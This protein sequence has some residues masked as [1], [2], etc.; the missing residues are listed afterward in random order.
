MNKYFSIGDKVYDLTE[1]YPIIIDFLVSKG[2]DNIKNEI[3]RKTIGK[4]ISLETAL[5]VKG[6]DVNEVERQIVSLIEDSSFDLSSGLAETFKKND[7]DLKISGILPCPIRVQLLESLDKWLNENDIKADY[8]LQAASMGL[9]WLREK[10]LG[11]SAKELSDI[12]LSAGFSL[13]FDNEVM[14]EHLKNN[15]FSNV[16]SVSRFNKCFDNKEID[17]KDPKN[18]YTIIGVVPAIFMVNTALLGDRQFPKS[19]ADLL[20]PEFENTIAL[21]MSDLDLF[22]AVLLG[23]YKEYGEEG[24]KKLGK[25]LLKSMHPA[26][27]IKEGGKRK[28]SQAPIITV[29]PYFF[30]WMAKEGSDLKPVW[31]DDGAIISPIFLITKAGAGEK[32]KALANYLF[33]KEMGNVMSANGKFPSTHPQVDNLLS[34]EQRFLWMGWDFIYNNDIGKLLKQTEQMFYSGIEER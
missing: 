18:Q 6:F 14:G 22:N 25:G 28:V 23:I 16:I 2:L 24:V 1:K 33:S 19:W 30:T 5:K 3:M 20:K 26:Q 32:T 9:D 15:V 8:E 17:L 34:D 12:Y 10:M 4:T 21:P 11:S 29:M 7:G 13:F 27:M 31:P